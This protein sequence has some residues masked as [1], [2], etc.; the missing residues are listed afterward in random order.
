MKD[1][2]CNVAMGRRRGNSVQTAREITDR[3]DGKPRQAIELDSKMSAAQ[4]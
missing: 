1:D 4:C 3:T 2:I